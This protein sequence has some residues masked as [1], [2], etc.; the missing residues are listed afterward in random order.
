MTMMQSL[1]ATLAGL[2]AGAEH[3]DAHWFTN[4]RMT[5][6]VRA[7]QTGGAFGAV[8]GIGPAGSSPP[9]HLHTREDEVFVLLEGSLFVRCGEETFRAEPGSI[10]FLPRGVPHT[11]LV[12]GD[13]PARLISFCFPGGFEEFF[14]AAGDPA[15]DD[16]LPP[17][18]P[19]DVARL[20][21]VGAEFGLQFVGPP[22]KPGD[23]ED[24]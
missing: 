21:Q 20:Q 5:I 6:M 3:G 4:N 16:G 17:N 15:A 18:A 24:R 10:T 9:L 23:G 19:P 13:E 7:E 11:F 12:E 22:L 1:M 2:N 14:V 8:E